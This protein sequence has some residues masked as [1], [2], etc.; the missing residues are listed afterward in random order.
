MAKTY[1]SDAISVLEVAAWTKESIET[2][3]V[4]SANSHSWNRGEYFMSLR[5][6]VA[7]S[8]VTPPLTES[9]LIIGRDEILARIKQN[10]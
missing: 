10:I 4:D 6:A 1:L 2:G 7:G 9:M 5:L 3:L 8:K